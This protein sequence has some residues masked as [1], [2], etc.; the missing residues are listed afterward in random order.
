MN[1]PKT[2]AI[3]T[4][5]LLALSAVTVSTALGQTVTTTSQGGL[6]FIG[7]PTFTINP[8]NSVTA[9]GEV[10]G[11][12]TGGEATLTAFADVIRTC[13]NNGGHN[14]PGQIRE[15][16]TVAGQVIFD[17]TNSGRGTFTVSTEAVTTASVAQCP[18]GMASTN[19]IVNFTSA[20]LVVTALNNP[21]KVATATA[22]F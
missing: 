7:T 8:D 20:E 14:P 13:T 19:V 15:T 11:A 2:A 6:K 3:F 5:A 12:G 9:T 17:T 21:N 16:V 10:S 18:P 4:A 22:I 1:A